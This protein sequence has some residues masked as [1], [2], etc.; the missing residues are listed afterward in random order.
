MSNQQ[1]T[2]ESFRKLLDE[3]EHLEESLLRE[4]KVLMLEIVHDNYLD[5]IDDAVQRRD[6]DTF[7]VSVRSL[8]KEYK[9]LQEVVSTLKLFVKQVGEEGK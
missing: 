5:I 3:A 7:G 6:Y 2:V 1:K 8:F 9:N 4:I